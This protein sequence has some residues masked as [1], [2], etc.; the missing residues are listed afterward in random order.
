MCV[1]LFEIAPTRSS[2]G[3]H[4]TPTESY[5]SASDK[6]PDWARGAFFRRS[7]PADFPK[8]TAAESL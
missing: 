8:E 1:L 7:L 6:V 5:V 4:T 2:D 3:S